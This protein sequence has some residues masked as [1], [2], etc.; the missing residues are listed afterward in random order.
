MVYSL[1][2]DLPVAVWSM[3]VIDSPIVVEVLQTRVIQR[4][5]S[6][7]IPLV[8]VCPDVVQ[9]GLARAG[10]VLSANVVFEISAIETENAGYRNPVFLGSTLRLRG[11]LT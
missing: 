10:K 7:A 5:Q 3:E 9:Y 4:V 8:G 2:P 1:H 6:A 11:S